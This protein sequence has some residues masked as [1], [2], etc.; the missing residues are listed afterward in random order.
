MFLTKRVQKVIIVNIG[1]RTSIEGDCHLC[2]SVELGKSVVR[3]KFK[4]LLFLMGIDDEKL[5][6][7][8]KSAVL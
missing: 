8:N 1:D 3:I 2:S 5:K 6:K 7:K 4:K